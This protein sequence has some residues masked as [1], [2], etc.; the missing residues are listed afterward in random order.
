MSPPRR[1]ACAGADDL[2]ATP[3]NERRAH[4][5]RARSTDT[6]YKASPTGRPARLYNPTHSPSPRDTKRRTKLVVSPNRCSLR[7]DVAATHRVE[8]RASTCVLRPTSLPQRPAP[9]SPPNTT[10]PTGPT[11][12]CSSVGSTLGSCLKTSTEPDHTRPAKRARV[13]FTEDVKVHDGLCCANRI[14]DELVWEQVTTY[15]LSCGDDVVCIVQR[16]LEDEEHA[17]VRAGSSHARQRSAS[18]DSEGSCDAPALAVPTLAQALTT[19]QQQTLDLGTR[20][21]KAEQRAHKGCGASARPSS[22]DVSVPV[23]PRGGGL[24]AKLTHAHL[25]PIL[26]LAEMVQEA[27]ED[28]LSG[29][30]P[31]SDSLDMGRCRD[32]RSDSEDSAPA[33]DFE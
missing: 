11:S 27:L 7:I 16:H 29:D 28:V 8:P 12:P 13:R 33:V 2:W 31:D 21:A 20:I 22:R 15:N 25:R 26:R 19:L 30:L 3:S 1:S 9:C 14:F 23:L 5:K 32:T 4:G 18:T 17:A 10:S 24:A 6:D